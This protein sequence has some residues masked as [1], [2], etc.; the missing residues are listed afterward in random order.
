MDIYPYP[1][2]SGQNGYSM[3]Q[4]YPRSRTICGY[5]NISSISKG[6]RSTLYQYHISI[7]HLDIYPTHCLPTHWA[8]DSFVSEFKGS[9][10][11]KMSY[12]DIEGLKIKLFRKDHIL[13]CQKMPKNTKLSSKELLGAQ[14]FSFKERIKVD[15]NSDS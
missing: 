15:K 13:S 6:Y 3:K 9:L 4:N 5:I 14:S 11:V 2:T 7:Q 12:G 1:I 8:F 10:S